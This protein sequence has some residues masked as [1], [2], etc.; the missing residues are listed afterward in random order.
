MLIRR[1]TGLLLLAMMLLAPAALAAD[2]QDIPGYTA[3]EGYQ[4]VTFGRYAT[5]KDGGEASILWRVLKNDGGEAYLLSEYI[6]FAAPVHASQPKYKSW[7]TSELYAYLNDT[8]KNDAFTAGEQSALLQRTEDQAL[9]TLLS[10]DEMKDTSIGFGTDSSRNAQGTEWAKRERSS[11]KQQLGIYDKKYSSWWSRDKRPNSEIN[12]QRRVIEGGKLGYASS[13]YADVGVR[14]AVYVDL[15][16]LEIASGKGTKEKP[17]VLT[18]GDEADTA[19]ATATPK[20]KKTKATATPKPEQKKDQA[21]ATPK[22]KKAK[23]TATPSVYTFTA[24]ANKKYINKKFPKLTA[25]GFLPEG[26]KEFVLEDTENGLWLYANQS[27]RIEITR[28]TGTN[29]KKQPLRWYEAQVFTKDSNTLFDTYA[30]DR[31]HYAVYGDRYKAKADVIAQQ[32]KLVFAINTDFFIYRFERLTE[33]RRKNRNAFYPLGLE[34]RNGE[35]L[36]DVPKKGSGYPPLDV[37]AMFPDGTVEMYENGKTTAEKLLKKHCMN[38]LSFGPI[39]VE[40]GKVLARSKEFGNTPNPRTAFGMVEPGHYICVM[41]ESR[42]A[43]SKGESCI[44]LGEKMAQLG[45]DKAIN[46]DGG[47][48]STMLFMGKQVNKTGNYGNITNRNQNELLGI[49]HSDAIKQTSK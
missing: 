28:K 18:A 36:F 49:G 19:E 34:I 6:L 31:E 2:A 35:T 15:N 13:A 37:M 22:P 7:E 47:A 38:A 1:M 8:F 44:W 14:P 39:L 46:L 9:V 29:S 24:G 10:F 26:K 41:V 45:C 27:L 32:H 3:K 30:Y 5:K 11:K 33:E 40:N 25:D 23:A 42:I 16:V 12:Q 43:E 20:A 17:Y 48:T 4:Y 21:T